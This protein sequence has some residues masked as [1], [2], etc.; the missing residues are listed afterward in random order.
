MARCGSAGSWL[1]SA[2]PQAVL[3]AQLAVV[4]RHGAGNDAE[5]GGLAGAVAADEPDALVLLH[6]ERRPVEQR[7]HAVGELGVGEREKRHM[8]RY[9]A[10]ADERR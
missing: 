10:T 2:A 8:F 1:T 7:R 9:E 5:E 6:G 4:E 3:P